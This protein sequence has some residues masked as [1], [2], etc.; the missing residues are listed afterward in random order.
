MNLSI[1]VNMLTLDY[2]TKFQ[3]LESRYTRSPELKEAYEVFFKVKE[4][5]IMWRWTQN[6]EGSMNYFGFYSPI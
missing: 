2:I 6:R 4:E 5:E 1:T 3:I